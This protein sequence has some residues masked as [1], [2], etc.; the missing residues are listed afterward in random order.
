MKIEKLVDILVEGNLVTLYRQAKSYK[1]S[2]IAFAQCNGAEFLLKKLCKELGY[3]QPVKLPE[4]T[5]TT[6]E[7]LRDCM[8]E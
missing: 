1:G 2:L 6:D 3:A 5:R 4:D 8:N 7:K